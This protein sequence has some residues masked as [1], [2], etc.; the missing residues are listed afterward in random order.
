MTRLLYMTLP[1]LALACIA[2][3][4]DSA[5]QTDAER[6]AARLLYIDLKR[7]NTAYADSMRVLPDS[8]DA[9]ALADRYDMAVERAYFRY[10]PDTDQ[11]LTQGEQDTVWLLTNRYIQARDR[12][13]TL[14][15]PMPS[16][17]DTAD[18]SGLRTEY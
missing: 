14:R 10:P 18:T 2:C 16:D 8:I 7:I 9:Q 4:P 6:Q 11:H 3:V 15:E 5:E 17:T 12:H 1:L 13:A